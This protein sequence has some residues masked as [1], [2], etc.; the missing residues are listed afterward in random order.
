MDKR[1]L[2]VVDKMPGNIHRHLVR[3][4]KDSDTTISGE[5]SEFIYSMLSRFEVIEPIEPPHGLI[6]IT[7]FSKKQKVKL[8]AIANQIGVPYSALIKV[9]LYMHIINKKSP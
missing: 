7:N 2:I 1:R 3:L 6:K 8:T 9:C 4:S 5:L